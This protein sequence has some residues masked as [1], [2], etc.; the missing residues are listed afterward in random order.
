MEFDI[1]LWGA[2]GGAAV[3][4]AAASAALLSYKKHR[5]QAKQTHRL[6]QRFGAEYV[7]AIS[8]FADQRKAE[9][10]LKARERDVEALP[11]WVRSRSS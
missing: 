9:L 8:D 6:K 3:I 1:L 4:L 11:A 2:L 5:A 7:R 10:E